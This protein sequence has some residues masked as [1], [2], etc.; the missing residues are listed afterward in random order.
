M[1]AFFLVRKQAIKDQEVGFEQFDRPL[2]VFRSK[3]LE[4]NQEIHDPAF[5]LYL[6][7]KK[8]FEVENYLS[9]ADGGFV[10]ATGTMIYKGLVGPAALNDLYEDFQHGRDLSESLTGEYCLIVYKHQQLSL[11]HSSSGLYHL[12]VDSEHRYFSSS[13]LAVRR[14]IAYSG[15]SGHPFR[16]IP[17]NR[18][19]SFRTT[20]PVHSGHAP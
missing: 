4:L 7:H 18:S 14:A 19:G 3:G 1:G 13:F 8:T 12:F 6:F 20:I 9:F 5:D 2:N 16:L 11:I 15:D 17:D 10:C